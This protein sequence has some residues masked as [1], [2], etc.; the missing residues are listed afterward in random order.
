MYPLNQ[1]LSR[2]LFLKNWYIIN[3]CSASYQENLF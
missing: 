1:F 3:S 2:E